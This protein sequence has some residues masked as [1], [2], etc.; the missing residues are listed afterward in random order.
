[1]KMFEVLVSNSVRNQI[2]N[3]AGK[4]GTGTGAGFVATDCPAGTICVRNGL[5]PCEGYE[6]VKDA[7]GNAVPILNGN[8]WYFNAATNGTVVGRTGDHTGLY[9]SNTYNVQ[10]LNGYNIG[11]KTLGLGIPAGDRGDFIELIVG[12]Q[13]GF[14]LDCFSTAPSA[15]VT[16]GYATIAN[17]E[18]VYSATAPT[19]AGVYL[20]LLRTKNIN[21]GTSFAGNGYVCEVAR[22]VGA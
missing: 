11:A 19:T 15:G 4:F 21:E 5:I 18:L 13:Y 17:G 2:Q 14:G 12:E 10:N 7:Q 6:D 22:A 3:V 20:I 9:V 16:T 8:T 1:M